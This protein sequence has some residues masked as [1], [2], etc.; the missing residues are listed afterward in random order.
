MRHLFLEAYFGMRPRIPWTLRMALRRSL[1][2]R[3][4]RRFSG[5]WHT[6]EL[7]GRAP[8]W[9][10]GWPEGKKFAFVLTHDVEGMSGLNRC[11][12]LAAME[13]QLGFRSSFNFVPEGEYDPPKALREYLT[14]HGFE[15]GVHDLRHDGKLFRSRKEFATNAQR[16]NHYL[17]EWGA[18]GFRSGFVLHNFDWLRDLNVAYDASS[19]DTD[20]FEPE[21]DGTNT[22]FPFWVGRDDGSGYVELPY[23]LPQDSTLFLLLQERGIE[24]WVQKLDWIALHGGMALVNVHPDYVRFDRTHRR[25]EY[26]VHFYQEF[27]KYVANRYGREAWFA[28]PRDIAAYIHQTKGRVLKQDSNAACA[29]TREGSGISTGPQATRA[30]VSSDLGNSLDWRLRGKRVA[31]VMFSYYPS[32]PRP[33][34]AVEA[35]VGK[36]M[37]VD[38][39]CLTGNSGRPCR[40]IVN[41]VDILRIPIRRRRGSVLRYG[42]EYGAF[43]LVSAAMLAV[44]SLTRGYDV[45]YVHNMPDFLVLSAL[46]PKLCGAKVI[47]DLHDPMPELLSTIFGLQ[48]KAP[49]VRLLK[50]VE[51]WSMAFSNAVITVNHTFARLFTSRSCPPAKMNII[52][53]SPDGQIFR[54]RP[55]RTSS[56]NGNILHGPFIVMYHGSMVRRNGVDLAVDA[57]ARVGKL[58]PNAELRLFGEHTAFLDQVMQSV[59]DMG[60][61]DVV[62]YLGRKSLED[63]VPAIDECDVG[64][65][66]NH[67]NV[68][69]ELNTPTRIF[70]YLALGKPVIAPRSAGVCDYF[71][72][73]SLIFFEL[74]NPEDLAQKIK[75][76]YSHRS[77]VAEIVGRGQH[78]YREHPWAVQQ[79]RLIEVIAGLLGEDVTPAE[80]PEQLCPARPIPTVRAS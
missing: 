74:G 61:Q 2:K 1:A 41:G 21:P 30:S 27:L 8:E 7:A 68:F 33:R 16:V 80:A 40:E 38:L 55:P 64:I 78:V 52:M 24:S 20:P 56:M 26:P 39:I 28:L 14:D 22:I 36:G 5:Y 70:E 77:E 44:R 54:L 17:T 13:M 42:F 57:F 76:V 67:R 79:Q 72:E 3:S 49:A 60:L 32:D 15:I 66:P 25:S 4:M 29:D 59:R 12:K 9:W 34:R 50:V 58:V 65:I 62:H 23:T 6:N 11:R 31:M 63:L 69:T 19:F 43:L 48:P 45:V 47:L 37:K 18:T 51:A 73:D 75:Y 35:L 53:N 46:V 10:S 71:D